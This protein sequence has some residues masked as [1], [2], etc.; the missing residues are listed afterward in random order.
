MLHSLITELYFLVFALCLL[1]AVHSPLFFRKFIEIDRF[2]LRAA[3]LYLGFVSN[4]LS[5]LPPPD[6][7]PTCYKPRLDLENAS[8]LSANQIQ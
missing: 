5:F 8:L 6:I 3:I 2:A 7:N 1:R 4:L